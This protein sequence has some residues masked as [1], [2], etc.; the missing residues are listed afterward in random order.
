MTLIQWSYLFSS[1]IGK[2]APVR[3]VRVSDS[4]CSWVNSELKAMMKSRY[5]LKQAAVSAKSNSISNCLTQRAGQLWVDF[6]SPMH[7]N[8][9]LF[10]RFR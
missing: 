3:D 10:G 2:H 6:T 4:N 5:R 8:V 1:I 7:K 9:Y